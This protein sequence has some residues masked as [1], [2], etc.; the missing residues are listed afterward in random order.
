[1]PSNTKQFPNQTDRDIVK[2]FFDDFKDYPAEVTSI[3]KFQSEVG[4]GK[5]DHYTESVLSGLGSYN[6][7]AEG[8]PVTY[9]Q[10]VEGDKKTVYFQKWTLAFQITEEM[11]DDSL[12]DNFDRMPSKLAK[13]GNYKK[14]SA[15]FDL[16]NSGFA[17]HTAND[18]QYIFHAT[19]HTTLKSLSTQA[20]RPATDAALSETSLQAAFEAFDARKDESGN[21]ITMTP[22]WLVVPTALRWTAQKLYKGTLKV[23]SADNDIN[24]VNPGNMPEQWTPF[25]SRWATASAA[26]FLLAAEHDGRFI[27]RWPLK[28]QS[29]DD[30]NTGSRLYKAMMRFKCAVWDYRGFY[31]TTP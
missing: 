24:T 1:M 31:G 7:T 9:D 13:N 20:T 27:W 26:W 15:W 23:G 12:D 22:K 19:A 2:R 17:T 5:G 18:G 4:K 14:D 25:V 10:P 8:Q 21:P 3:A 11:L 16:L 30:F 28:L 29:S 6:L